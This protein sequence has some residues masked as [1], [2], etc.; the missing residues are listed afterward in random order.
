MCRVVCK[1]FLEK[2][3]GINDDL[4]WQIQSKVVSF[5]QHWIR[6]YYYQDFE[7]SPDDEIHIMMEELVEKM[8]KHFRYNNKNKGFYYIFSTCAQICCFR[9][10]VDQND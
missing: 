2:D 6:N 8:Q 7:L 5:I 10:D 3:V 4:Q 1:G 9:T